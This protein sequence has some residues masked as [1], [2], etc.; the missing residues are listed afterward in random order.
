MSEWVVERYQ[1]KISSLVTIQE[2]RGKIRRHVEW[3]SFM[4][5]ESR[6]DDEGSR[7]EHAWDR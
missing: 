5:V 4:T 3:N 2:T 1:A 7:V 6:S